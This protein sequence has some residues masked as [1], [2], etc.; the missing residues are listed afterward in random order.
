MDE[1]LLLFLVLWYRQA[2]GFLVSVGWFSGTLA[3]GTLESAGVSGV[4]VGIFYKFL[5]I[6]SY[7][8]QI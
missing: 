8:A 1:L 5:S 7:N 3:A 6:I 4:S 2:V